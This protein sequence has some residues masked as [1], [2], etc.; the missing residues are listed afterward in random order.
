MSVVS[1][2]TPPQTTLFSMF[3]RPLKRLDRLI[4][5]INA[6]LFAIALGLAVLNVAVVVAL[7]M[8]ATTLAGADRPGVAESNLVGPVGEAP[9]MIRTE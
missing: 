5:E 9:M 4:G 2:A 8:P 1:G 7:K 3:S 6:G